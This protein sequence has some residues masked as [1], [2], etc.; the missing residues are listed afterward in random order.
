MKGEEDEGGTLALQMSEDISNQK[1]ADIMQEE[2][3]LSSTLTESP[4]REPS[5]LPGPPYVV[6]VS[7][8]GATDE[9]IFFLFGGESTIKWMSITDGKGKVEI[10]D[11]DS[12]RRVLALDGESIKDETLKVEAFDIRSSNDVRM[13]GGI[14]G[15]ARQYQRYQDTRHDQ[16]GY[17]R[18]GHRQ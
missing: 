17:H 15:G 1:W 11:E 16:Q 18:G 14:S 2:V 3:M 4:E 8:T 13:V 6:Q 10:H 5:P 7:C 9:E 12:M